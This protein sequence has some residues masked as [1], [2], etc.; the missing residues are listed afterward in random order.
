[1]FEKKFLA[2][3]LYATLLEIRENALTEKNWRVYHLT[4]ILHNV[5]GSL[6]DGEEAKKEYKRLLEAVE[7]L[8]I[9]DW[10]N[11]RTQEF[12]ERFPGDGL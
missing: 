12:N 3:V 11:K 2:Y 1:M 9:D 5:P 8:K 6:L 10:L 7:N 4:D